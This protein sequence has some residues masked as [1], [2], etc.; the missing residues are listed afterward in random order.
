MKN[1]IFSNNTSNNKIIWFI[2]SSRSNDLL[3]LISEDCIEGRDDI[4]DDFLLLIV[5]VFGLIGVTPICNFAG[6]KDL[7]FGAL[8]WG[9]LGYNILPLYL[10]RC[11]SFLRSPFFSP[12]S[13]SSSFFH[14]CNKHFINITT[15]TISANNAET[16]SSEIEKTDDENIDKYDTIL[17]HSNLPNFT[18]SCTSF[19]NGRSCV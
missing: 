4:D 6:D 8:A 15:N 19:S 3:S 16:T 13:F 12:S 17:L 1:T 7:L 10:R 18:S 11:A 2:Y 14:E 5:L 9:D